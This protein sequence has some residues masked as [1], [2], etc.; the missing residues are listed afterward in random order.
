M[1]A[2]FSQSDYAEDQPYAHTILAFHVIRAG[3]TA[4]SVLS[5][6]SAAITPVIS[7]LYK[8]RSITSLRNISPGTFRNAAIVH[9]SRGG[10]LGLLFGALAVTGQMWG[11]EDIEWKDRSWRLLGNK[12]QVET[13]NWVLGGV[14]LGAA[15][16]LIAGRRGRLPAFA[17]RPATAVIGGATIGSATGV[18][19]MLAKNVVLAGLA[20]R[21]RSSFQPPLTV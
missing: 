18:V 11:R 21:Q 13:D 19:V 7:T 8:T 16:A 17:G 5:L 15:G 20:R 1:T 3:F 14:V 9:A 4:G 12:T 2:I 10:P 6:P